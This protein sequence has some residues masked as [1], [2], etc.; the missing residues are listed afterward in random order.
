VLVSFDLFDL[1]QTRDVSFAAVKGRAKKGVDQ[2]KR[3]FRANHACTQHKHVHIVVFDALT[4]AI[5]IM[6]NAGAD[7]VHLVGSNAHT[8]TAAADQDAAFG[9]SILQ[10][11]A[12]VTRKIRVI[13]A[14]GVERTEI[15]DVMTALSKHFDNGSFQ[16]KTAVV[17]GNCNLHMHGASAK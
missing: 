11:F 2:F 13:R 14:F 7:P 4:R 8:H 3:Q 16:G 6:R 17:G 5:C 12:D 1:L 10:C 9:L 15:K